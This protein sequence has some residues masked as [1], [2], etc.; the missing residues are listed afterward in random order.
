MSQNGSV[1]TGEGGKGMDEELQKELKK[2]HQFQQSSMKL[3]DILPL[4][5]SGAYSN[6][7]ECGTDIILCPECEEWTH[8]KFNAHSC[9]LDLLGELT[10][11]N[12]D[13]DDDDIMLWIKTDEFNWFDL[14][15]QRA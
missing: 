10:V 2:Y 6:Y 8:V 9:L 12:I 11:E 4:I 1:L 13:A 3:K 7:D 5:R 14:R 15:K